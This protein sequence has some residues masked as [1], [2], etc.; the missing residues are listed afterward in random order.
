M[1]KVKHFETVSGK[2]VKTAEF[3]GYSIGDRLLEGLMFQISVQEDGTLKAS[4]K[5]KDK[6][7]AYFSDFNQEKFLK[8]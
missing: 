5:D 1:S 3:D 8:L 6:D 2:I 4:V 7:K